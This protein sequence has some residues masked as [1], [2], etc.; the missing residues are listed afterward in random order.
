MSLSS[1]L[2]E[3]RSQRHQVVQKNVDY[4]QG[5][6]AKDTAKVHFFTFGENNSFTN[7]MAPLSMAKD[8]SFQFF[9]TLPLIGEY[10]KLSGNFSAVT[11]II[12]PIS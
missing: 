12:N 11:C 1:P 7:H 3:E 9:G 4:L 6:K 2:R 8:N 5:L 10:F